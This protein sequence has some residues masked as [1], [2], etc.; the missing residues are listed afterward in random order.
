DANGALELSIQSGGLV[1][2]MDHRLLDGLDDTDGFVL[3][4]LAGDPA[5]SPFDY[6]EAVAGDG[7]FDIEPASFLP[8]SGRPATIFNPAAMTAGAMSAGPEDFFLTVPLGGAVLDLPVQGAIIQGTVTDSGAPPMLALTYET[9]TISGYVES[10]DVRAAINTFMASECA[11]L[12]L[13]GDMYGDG[14]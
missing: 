1:L 7:H 8:G 5:E 10:E 11:C 3:T 9:G 12:G 4:V 14:A 6:A 13:S 2:L